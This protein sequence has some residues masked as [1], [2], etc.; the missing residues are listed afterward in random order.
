MHNFGESPNAVEE[1]S[2]SQILEVNAPQ[3]YYLSE[4]ACR[5]ILRRCA[6]RGKVLPAILLSALLYQGNV[7][8]TA[9]A[10]MSG[11][12]QPYVVYSLDRAAFNQGKNAQYDPEITD[13]GI[14]STLVQKGPSAVCYWDG[15]Q[16]TGCLTANNAGGEQRMPDIRNFNGVI[17]CE[18]PRYIVRRLTPTECA[19]LQGMPDWWCQDI[20]HSDAAE[21]KMWGNGMAL[22]C[23]LYVFEGIRDMILRE[24]ENHG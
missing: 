14:A 4:T 16:K 24:G 5:G 1:S 7:T 2:L 19:R 15:S 3:K 10:G 9:A 17:Q 11:N 12:N 8:T 13:S 21:Y 6:N 22:P 20:K 23:V 18:H